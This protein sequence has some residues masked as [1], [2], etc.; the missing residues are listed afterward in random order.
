MSNI[1]TLN[2]KLDAMLIMV[3]A[4][5][6]LGIALS[7]NYYKSRRTTFSENSEYAADLLAYSLP[8]EAARVLEENIRRQPLSE[9]GLKM[10]KALAEIC[11]NEL[12]DFDKALGQ[13]LYI[14][15]FAPDSAI[16]SGTEEKINY[17]LT[18]LGRV[19]DAERRNMLNEGINPIV[20]TV[21]S[22]TVVQLGNKQA[23]GLN[24]LKLRL[25]QIGLNEKDLTK[26][27][28][29]NIL[30]Q[31]THE[32]LLARAANRENL[33]KDPEVI[34]MLKK[35]ENN[36]LMTV[37]LQKFVF[38]DVKTDD[39]EKRM[40]LLADEITKLSAKEELK[41]NSDVLNKAFGFA[42]DSAKIDSSKN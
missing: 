21:A 1:R 25:S 37:Y 34:S 42:T 31:M 33:K 23:I 5:L 19:Y 39:K 2:R 6:I 8:S 24:E 3:I 11:M 30:N 22:D 40:Q 10:R 41:I 20:N 13:L 26:E 36:V 32:M 28:V 15:R 27:N 17:C 7:Y 14:K 9:K 29:T 4:M 12:N 16:A 18:R 35:L 38:K